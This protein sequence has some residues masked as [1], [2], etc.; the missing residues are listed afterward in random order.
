MAKI[1]SCKS[2][3]ELDMDAVKIIED[4]V[5]RLLKTQKYAVLAIPGGRSIAGIFKILESHHKLPWDKV[6]IFMADERLVPIDDEQSNFKLAWDSFIRNLIEHGTLPK[7]NVHPFVMDNDSTDSGISNYEKELNRY[8]GR[9]DIII[10][11]VG[12][13]GHVGALYPGHHSVNDDSEFFITMYDSPKP[14]KDRMSLSRNLVFKADTAIALFY[15]EGKKSAFTKFRDKN[16]G[17]EAC[18]VKLINEIKNSYV[19]TDL[20]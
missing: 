5:N 14:P 4:S 20:N 3:R 7:E 8:G 11:G 19:I 10:L 15:G 16:L 1:I 2:K 12:E 17:F 9:Y 6:H 13:D 18:P